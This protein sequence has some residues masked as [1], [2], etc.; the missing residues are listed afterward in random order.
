[1]M[2]FRSSYQKKRVKY[3]INLAG[4]LKPNADRKN[5][6]VDYPNG[7]SKKY[8]LIPLNG[9]KVIDGSKI[10][11]G[12]KPETEPLDKTELAKEISAIIANLAQV[13]AVLSLA[14]SN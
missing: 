4:G 11:I 7:E 2:E 5:I 8:D 13:I 10:R 12:T 3:Y 9:P 6:W 14:G 1:M